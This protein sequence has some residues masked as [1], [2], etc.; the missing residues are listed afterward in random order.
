MSVNS[1]PALISGSD[2]ILCV[3]GRLTYGTGSVFCLGAAATPTPI[4][5]GP[6]TPTPTSTPAATPR[7]TPTATPTPTPLT[8]LTPNKTVFSTTDRLEVSA[9]VQAI[10]SPFFPFVR[11]VKPGGETLY[12]VRGK[13][14][15]ARPSAY[16][17]GGPFVLKGPISGYPVLE[18]EFTGVPA[19]TY[20]LEGGAVDT[21]MNHL[22][23]VDRNELR[24]VEP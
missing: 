22:G 3:A 18:T 12:Y 2:G 13:G 9:D 10:S 11:L 1:S 4:P 14:L 19:G 17:E 6:P 20:Y 16:L 15:T 5:T 7:A 23:P 24:V 8:D 21:G